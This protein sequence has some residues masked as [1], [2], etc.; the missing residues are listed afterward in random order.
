MFIV[1]FLPHV[2]PAIGAWSTITA[3]PG[4]YSTRRTYN[5]GEVGPRVDLRVCH[6]VLLWVF[7]VGQDGKDEQG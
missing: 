7:D 3:G 1:F 6:C 4:Y 2:L 5:D